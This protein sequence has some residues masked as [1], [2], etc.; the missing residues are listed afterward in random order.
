[1]LS[2]TKVFS[3]KDQQAHLQRILTKCRLESKT[4]L[5]PTSKRMKVHLRICNI[6]VQKL[7]QRQKIDVTS[8]YWTDTEI[9][10]WNS[11]PKSSSSI[12]I[13]TYLRIQWRMWNTHWKRIYD[14]RDFHKLDEIGNNANIGIRSFTTWKQKNSVTQC[15]L[16]WGLKPGPLISSPTL[17]SGLTL[18]LLLRRSL[19]FFSS[20]T[21]FWDL[22]DSLRIN[23]TWLYKEPTVPVLQANAKLVQKEECWTWN[24]R[25]RG[26][27][28]T[29]GNILLLD[30][31]VFM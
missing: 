6:L 24:Q 4:D 21:W 12:S 22:N 25:S 14:N 1:M 18:H 27:I 29:G 17:L 16:Q 8:V 5:I 23:R 15:Y 9:V 26:S 3:A 7:V 2:N 13:D 19:N 28:L 20:T 30:F 11:Y 31:F 10:Q